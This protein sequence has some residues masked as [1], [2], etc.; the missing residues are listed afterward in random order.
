VRLVKRLMIQGCF[1]DIY[2]VK[3]MTDKWKG[4]GMK[5][6]KDIVYKVA[7]SVPNEAYIQTAAYDNHILV[8]A[9]HGILEEKM[10]QE[11]ISPRYEFYRFSTGR[12]LTQLAREKLMEVALK[13]D[14]DFVIMYDSDMLLPLDT[15]EALLQDM[16]DHPEIDVLA[17]LAFMRNPPHYAVIYNVIEGYDGN[18]HQEYYYNQYVKKYPKNKL[19]ECDAVGFGAACI[20]LSFVRE[21]M[22]APFF[23]ST[24]PTGE[25]IFFCVNAK[26]AGGRIFMD[27]RIKLGH[28]ANA[29]IIDEDYAEKWWKDNKHD[30]GKEDTKYRTDLDEKGVDHKMLE[31]SR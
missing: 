12:L 30:M 29:P 6:S 2:L 17:P 10:R 20:R 15:I 22:K 5:K 21:K 28:I 7:V 23:M 24:T 3:Q 19:V 31:A 25:D 9:H 26:K 11:G 8:A 4:Q 27:T 13:E 16:V 1:N 14:M 18:R